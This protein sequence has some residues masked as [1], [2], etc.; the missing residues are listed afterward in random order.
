MSV[1]EWTRTGRALALALS[2]LGM[3]CLDAVP[4][5]ASAP[6][7]PPPVPPGIAAPLGSAARQSI[8]A[9][10]HIHGWSN[11][12]ANSRPPSIAWHTQQYAAGGVDLIWWTDHADSYF[13]R[14]AD[15]RISP[16]TPSQV[17][18]NTWLVGMW[19]PNAFGKAFLGG[20]TPPMLDSAT[21][22][23]RVMLPGGD[24][25]SADTVELSLGVI[26]N[27]HIRGAGLTMLSRPLIGDPTFTMT[28]GRL[29][30]DSV[31]PY[32]RV[33]VPLAWHP[34]P[35]GGYRQ[36]L[37]YRFGPRPDSA[38]RAQ[39]DTLVVY[40]GWAGRDS[41]TIAI[42]PA[43]EA[44]LLPDGVD[45]TTDEY[46]IQFIVPRFSNA[47]ELSFSLPTVVN[48]RST[49]AVQM[50][51]AVDEAHAMASAYG[52]RAMWG[53][54]L[55]ARA[56][57]LAGTKW[58]PVF[59]AGAHMPAY[60]PQ[61]IPPALEGSLVGTPSELATTVKSLGG[62][63]AI[64]HPFGTS[65]GPVGTES[66][67]RAQA[68]ELGAF[69]VQH[70]GWGADLIEVGTIR[71]G[72]VA[73]RG[74]LDLL[75]YL[76][77][78]GL[79]LCGTG[80]TDAHGGEFLRDPRP[81]TEDQYNFVTWIGGVSRLA[82]GAQLIAALRSCNVSFGDPFYTHGG[83]W[84]D[85]RTDVNGH[86]A[87]TFDAAGASPSADLFLYEAELDSTGSGHSPVYRRFGEQVARTASVPVGGCKPGFARVEAWAGARPIAFSNP[88][89]LAPDPT[90][91]TAAGVAP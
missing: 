76:W 8:S 11:H 19:G 36:V 13:G 48:A 59:G 78:S 33:L 31:F 57:A 91:C 56:G 64:A 40:R 25:T 58:Q 42:Q 7:P 45:N 55:G 85:V 67:Q 30:T 90:K 49:A 63:T 54:E 74:H 17:L 53:L 12:G 18:P 52:I 84:I 51:P 47:A 81:G 16:T 69:L 77:A 73:L 83:L 68:Q 38:V 65:T 32:V 21:G 79:R 71:R 46:R 15:F 39:G 72:L 3:A 6:S 41:M 60:L 28:V 87:A 20:V 1:K 27:G 75:D 5:G 35:G 50:P 29:H 24:S 62:V 2:T 22:Q 26:L 43:S 70:G 9:A 34:R 66:E 80:V 23:V 14:V 4:P 37:D 86:Q 82:S 88:V 44:A 61:D 89:V 10:M